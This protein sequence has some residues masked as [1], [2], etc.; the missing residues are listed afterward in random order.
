MGK[1]YFSS[2]RALKINL[3]FLKTKENDT[4]SK[5]DVKCRIMSYKVKYYDS[6]PHQ[7]FPWES[8]HRIFPEPSSGS[9]NRTRSFTRILCPEQG[10]YPKLY[11]PARLS[12]PGT[13]S[14]SSVS[15]VQNFHNAAY[16]ITQTAT[17][18]QANT[19]SRAPF[20]HP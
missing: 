13:I 4:Y 20:P 16:P 2:Q 19:A 8:F 3:Q 6:V 14:S 17:A 15:P 18:P 7:I 11:P 1:A 10:T 5:C 12:S 9:E